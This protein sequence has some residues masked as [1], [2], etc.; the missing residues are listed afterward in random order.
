MTRKLR[1]K[2]SSL[3]PSLLLL[4]TWFPEVVFKTVCPCLIYRWTCISIALH[5]KS[6]HCAL[7]GLAL[8]VSSV[9]A[10]KI[11]FAG[12]LFTSNPGIM[13]PQRDCW[14]TNLLFALILSS[15]REK[16]NMCWTLNFCQVIN[17]NQLLNKQHIHPALPET[18]CLYSDLFK[19]AARQVWETES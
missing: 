12:D 13:Q 19:D 4:V 18:C 17:N 14:N 5:H 11:D 9:D 8:D 6:S 10:N 15:K 3:L 16:K 1:E 2:Q 7:A